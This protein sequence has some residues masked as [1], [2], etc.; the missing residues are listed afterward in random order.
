MFVTLDQLR[1]LRNKDNVNVSY[2][3]GTHLSFPWETRIKENNISLEE[4][5]QDF[6]F[7]VQCSDGVING[8]GSFRLRPDLR[9][10]VTFLNGAAGVASEIKDLII[11]DII[12]FFREKTVKQAVTNFGELNRHLD[13]QFADHHAD[14]EE[15]YGINVTDVT[16]SMM[17][18]SEDVQKTL[19]ALSEA[20]AIA[21]GTEILL[22]IPP[23]KLSEYLEQNKTTQ[24]DVKE[25]R[26]RF[27]A[28]SGNLEGMD[29]SRNEYD[30]NI[31]G[32]DSETI[33]ELGNIMKIPG[34]Q[35]YM[36]TQGK[37]GNKQNGKNNASKPEQDKGDQ[38]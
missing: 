19:S 9:S 33:H 23:G 4:A 24:A 25:A 11:S 21:A 1:S 6:D 10:A 22:A 2:G 34:V 36:M 17:L 13:K 38:P 15:R 16:V 8:S 31:R 37:K 7:K 18:P 32:L 27:L 3:P 29:I 12:K 28:I 30:F 20:T 35:A 5:A 14:V 26:D